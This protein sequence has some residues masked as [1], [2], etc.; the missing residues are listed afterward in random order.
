M[1]K[2]RIALAQATQQWNQGPEAAFFGDAE[3]F[4]DSTM[5]MCFS[6]ISPSQQI[7]SYNMYPISCVAH[8]FIMFENENN[9]TN[10]PTFTGWPVQ[11][12]LIFLLK[13][14]GKS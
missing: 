9:K 8:G 7:E 4:G 6:E 12:S 10:F 1:K 13:R 11:M 14:Q 5:S 3:E 2:A